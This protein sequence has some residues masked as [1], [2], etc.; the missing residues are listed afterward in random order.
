MLSLTTEEN[1]IL[2]LK[3]IFIQLDGV[4]MGSLLGTTFAKISLYHYETK[5]LKDC[6][7]PSNHFVTENTLITFLHSL[8]NQNK[9]YRLLTIRSIHPLKM[10]KIT[11]FHFLDAMICREKDKLRTIIFRKDT[12][13]GV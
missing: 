11:P 6:P 2:D 3:K 1:I 8:K 9:F 10:E 7:K 12:F 5:S 4:T 13:S